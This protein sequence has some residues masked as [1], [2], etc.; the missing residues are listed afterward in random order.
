MQQVALDLGVPRERVVL[1]SAS[2]DTADQAELLKAR[3]GR[4]PFYLV[5]SA[6]HMPRA[7]RLF[8][9]AGTRPLAAPTD[10]QA[11]WTRPLEIRDFV[12]SAEALAMTENAFYEYLGLG[13]N[14]LIQKGGQ[15][16]IYF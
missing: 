10:F 6:G 2:W 3:L 5:T 4:D 9:R 14:W 11:V 16:P 12:P 7:M 13:W 8:I 1:E 15:L